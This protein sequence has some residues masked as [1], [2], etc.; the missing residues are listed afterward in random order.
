MTRRR[1]I[2]PGNGAEPVEV[3]ADYLPEPRSPLIF[4]D[5]PGYL[6]EGTGLWVEGR[7]QRREDLKRSGCR[8]WEGLEQEKKEAARRARYAEEKLDAS[9]TRTAAETFYQLPPEKRRI[10]TGRR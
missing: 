7:A 10:L 2:Y 4:G 3:T 5:I 1:W 8:P 9:L 6:S